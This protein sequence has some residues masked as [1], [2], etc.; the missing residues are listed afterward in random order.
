MGD[1]NE[2]PTGQGA[3]CLVL[4]QATK[5]LSVALVWNNGKYM[6]VEALL[7]VTQKG[8]IF[9]CKEIQS[10]LKLPELNSVKPSDTWWLSHQC[11]IRAIYR[12]LLALIIALQQLYEMSGDAETCGLST[13]LATYTGVAN[14]VFLS[15]VLDILA[16]TNASMQRKLGDFRKLPVLLKVTVDQLEQVKEEKIEWFSSVE[17]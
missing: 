15:E 17:S 5:N 9:Q 1:T 6:Y 4:P 2:L 12:E 11:C 8:R 16:K 7:L 13:L 10:V 14:V 3:H